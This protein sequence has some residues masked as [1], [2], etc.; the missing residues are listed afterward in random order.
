MNEGINSSGCGNIGYSS[1][2][3]L[4][5][6]SRETS[7]AYNLCL[8]CRMVLTFCTVV[9][10][11][12]VQTLKPFPDFWMDLLFCNKP[13]WQHHFRKLKTIIS[14]A[15]IIAWK[16]SRRFRITFIPINFTEL[17][18]SRLHDIYMHLTP[19]HTRS[20]SFHIWCLQSLFYECI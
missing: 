11:W 14:K 5:F 13:V 16:R 9:L 12:S 10:P 7:F 15:Q 8:V 20:T 3:H 6:K 18:C 4:K 2:S 1:D 19:G 17:P